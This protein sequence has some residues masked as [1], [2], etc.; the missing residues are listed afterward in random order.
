MFVLPAGCR[1]DRVLETPLLTR[2]KQPRAGKLE[3]A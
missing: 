1:A 3:E 2:V